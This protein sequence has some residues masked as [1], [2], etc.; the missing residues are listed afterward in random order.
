MSLYDDH[1]DGEIYAASITHNINKIVIVAGI[2]EVLWCPDEV[3]VTKA[4]QLIEPLMGGI[5]KLIS[6]AYINCC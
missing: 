6:T 2:Y 5:A 4:Y 3:S 1:S